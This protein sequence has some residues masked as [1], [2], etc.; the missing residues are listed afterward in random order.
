MHQFIMPLLVFQVSPVFNM[1]SSFKL[2]DLNLSLEELPH[3]KRRISIDWDLC[4]LCQEPKD[5]DL[6]D[7]S[8][9]K[10]DKKDEGFETLDRNL[11]EF[12]LIGKR[13]CNVDIE[14]LSEGLGI[15]KNLK[16][17]KAKWHKSC[18]LQCSDSK[19]KK[20]RRSCSENVPPSTP[21][22]LPTRSSSGHS[23]PEVSETTCI[24]CG[25]KAVWNSPL[26]Q[27]QPDGAKALKEVAT[28]KQD[29][30]VL[31][32]LQSTKG[33]WIHKN[34][35]ASYMYVKNEV[36]GASPSDLTSRAHEASLAFVIKHIHDVKESSVTLPVFAVASLAQIYSSKLQEHGV[37]TFVHSTRLRDVI[38]TACPDLKAS[39]APGQQSLL[40]FRQDVDC[41]IRAE[42]AKQ[43]TRI[44][45]EA[46]KEVRSDIFSH[47]KSNWEDMSEDVRK[48]VPNSLVSLV[49]LVIDGKDCTDEKPDPVVSCL[50]Q[51]LYFHCR[52]KQKGKTR[53][54]DANKETPV[55]VYVATKVYGATTSKQLIDTMFQLGLSISY[56]RLHTI[57]HT[58]AIKACLQYKKDKVVCPLEF[59]LNTFT[60]GAVDNLDHNTS[61][62][63]AKKAFHNTVISL[64]QHGAPG[65]RKIRQS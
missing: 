38:L 63:S 52:K 15:K 48:Y 49:S 25:L 24:I 53:R 37:D 6:R 45:S 36:S 28:L 19:L 1:N 3:R 59:E 33:A 20:A 43:D 58:R 51:L 17:N 5:A 56:D 30:H 27:I 50:A 32:L 54:H 40:R 34:C 60:T 14:Q 9:N 35:R 16:D 57:L 39:G 21:S 13:P 22:P 12:R 55:P 41:A 4:V 47:P 23:S 31:V 26:Q 7:P 65:K 46:A 44:L 42:C 18:F 2:V 8:K 61:S 11:R 62:M 29:S 64:M 10:R